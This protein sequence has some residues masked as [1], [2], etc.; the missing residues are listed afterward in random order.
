MK[1]SPLRA[2]RQTKDTSARRRFATAS[3]CAV[4]AGTFR[5]PLPHQ[6][7]RIA[8]VHVGAAGGPAVIVLTAIGVVAVDG[9]VSVVIDE[10]VA[11][12][13]PRGVGFTGV[14]LTGV[15]EPGVWLGR[16][17]DGA[18]GAERRA[19]ACHECGQGESEGEDDGNVTHGHRGGPGGRRDVEAVTVIAVSELR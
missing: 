2:A 1:Y 9:A 3:T 10:V 4:V 18:L 19:P 13:V 16:P 14:W 15:G 6:A 5:G 8:Q 11:D 17:S 12:L 7:Q